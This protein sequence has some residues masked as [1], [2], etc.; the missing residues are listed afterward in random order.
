MHSHTLS[1]IHALF[2]NFPRERRD[3]GGARIPNSFSHTAP[4][5][6]YYIIRA[7]AL[8]RRAHISMLSSVR[9]KAAAIAHTRAFAS[10][11]LNFQFNLAQSRTLLTTTQGATTQNQYTCIYTKLRAH[12]RLHF[13]SMYVWVIPIWARE[14]ALSPS[15]HYTYLLSLICAGKAISVQISLPPPQEPSPSEKIFLWVT[16]AFLPGN[17]KKS[18]LKSYGELLWNDGWRRTAC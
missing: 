15:L 1:K 12:T 2:C 16:K 18:N 17:K 7:D 6:P 4:L 14:L 9:H 5:C 3:D 8:M 13:V 11:H 10:I